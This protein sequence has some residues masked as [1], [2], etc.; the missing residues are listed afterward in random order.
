M[1]HIEITPKLIK[2]HNLT[3]SEYQKVLDILGR[4]PTMSLEFSQQCGRSI[5]LTNQQKNI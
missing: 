4:T 5:A 3:E 2:D 1:K